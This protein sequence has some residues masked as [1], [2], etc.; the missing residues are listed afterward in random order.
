M[1]E[2]WQAIATTQ[3]SERSAEFERFYEKTQKEK[4]DWFRE[5]ADRMDADPN[6]GNGQP[7]SR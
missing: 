6:R 5:L 7:L 4:Y 2:N 3:D 1:R